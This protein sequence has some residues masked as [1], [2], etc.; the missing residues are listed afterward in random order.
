[1]SRGRKGHYRELF[2]NIRKMGYLKVRVDGDVKDL[3]YGMQADRFK[4]HDIEI[5][6]D[7]IRLDGAKGTDLRL[8]QSIQTAL[9]H[10]K[11]ALMVLHA[12][13]GEIRPFSRK[14]M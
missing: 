1:M 12:E 9:K 5:V 8:R 13:T 10:G 4:V 14:L 11:E 2:E 3:T 6:I 7:R